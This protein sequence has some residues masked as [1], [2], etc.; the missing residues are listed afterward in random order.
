MVD[1]QQTTKGET[2]SGPESTKVCIQVPNLCRGERRIILRHI[3][4]HKWFEHIPTEK[5][6]WA[7]RSFN[8]KYGWLQREMY[9]SSVCHYGVTNNCMAF[10][11]YLEK[12]G[13]IMDKT[14]KVVSIALVVQSLEDEKALPWC[15]HLPDFLDK[16]EPIITA[17]LSEHKQFNGIYDDREATA[18]FVKKF[19]W[20]P[21]EIYCDNVC[22][23]S[24]TCKVY[25][26]YLGRFTRVE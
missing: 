25:Q 15:A 5:F 13:W 6:D 23:E 3:E 20:A 19:A 12:H 2:K 16:F 21:R 1:E 10:N 26:E 14:K 9:C 17:H 7:V 4:Q 24:A 22:K 18:N 8:D 11:R